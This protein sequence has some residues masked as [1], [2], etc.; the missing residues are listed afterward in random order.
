MAKTRSA[1]KVSH[2]QGYAQYHLCARNTEEDQKMTMKKK[3]KINKAKF[4]RRYILPRSLP[5]SSFH[6]NKY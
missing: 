6:K 4:V 2:T 1:Q 3:N 5:F